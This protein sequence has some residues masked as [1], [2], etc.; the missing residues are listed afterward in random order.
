RKLTLATQRVTTIAGTGFAG[1]SGDG[2]DPTLA[3]MNIGEA[4]SLAFDP[5]G[6]LYVS[7][8]SN[9]I[10][11]IDMTN[12]LISTYAGNGVQGSTGDNGLATQAQLNRP[13]GIVFDDSGNLYINEQLGNDMR[14]VAAPTPPNAPGVISTFAT[15][16]TGPRGLVRDNSG[17]LYVAD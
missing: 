15:G 13:S 10:R 12:N 9:R 2:G 6:N 7:F 11:R 1:F 17:Y 8:D 5:A 4:T 16:F 3:Q 14:R